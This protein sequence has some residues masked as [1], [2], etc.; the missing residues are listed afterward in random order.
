MSILMSLALLVQAPAIAS[1]SPDWRVVPLA[2]GRWR[3]RAIAGGS[4]AAWSDG[5]GTV[6]LTISCALAS[7]RVLITRLRGGVPMTV[8]TTGASRMLVT[9][10][11]PATDPL[12]DQIAFSRGR[13]AVAAPGA[14]LLVV[15]SWAEPAKAIED[16]RK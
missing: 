11:L 14:A 12:L 16:C 1:V 6:Q 7:R 4:E 15:P 5:V 3:Y 13:F 9:P 8:S 10:N 2:V